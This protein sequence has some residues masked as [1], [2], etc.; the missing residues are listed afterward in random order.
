MFLLALPIPARCS[1]LCWAAGNSS[2]TR[3]TETSCTT[4]PRIRKRSTTSTIRPLRRRYADLPVRLSRTLSPTERRTYT[5]LP[6][7][8]PTK[9]RSS[10]RSDPTAIGLSTALL[11]AIWFGTLAGLIEGLGLLLFQR[12]NWASW[13]PMLHVS[14]PILWISPLVDTSL[15]VA[16]T[17]LTFGIAWGVAGIRTRFRESRLS[18]RANSSAVP[19][20]FVLTFATVYDWLTL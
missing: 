9:S 14:A 11:I 20:I 12:L 19:V 10:V 15:F 3:S 13:G 1:P 8:E 6:F 5:S 4:G 2:S 7:V 17:V 18:P 16:L